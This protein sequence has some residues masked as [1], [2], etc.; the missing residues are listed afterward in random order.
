MFSN[1]KVSV[2]W[3]AAVNAEMLKPGRQS[4]VKRSLRKLVF[5]IIYSV[6]EYINMI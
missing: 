3:S 6:Y 2:H 1:R 4:V 5:V